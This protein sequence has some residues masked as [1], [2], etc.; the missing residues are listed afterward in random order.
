MAIRYVTCVHEL[1]LTVARLPLDSLRVVR[2]PC[3]DENPSD[4]PWVS[5]MCSILGD[6]SSGF[7]NEDLAT[8]GVLKLIECRS[9][10]GL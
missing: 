1:H 4:I 5:A 2:E 3:W 9:S 10:F 8:S 6:E 7:G